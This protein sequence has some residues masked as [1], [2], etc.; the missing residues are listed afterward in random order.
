MK[1]S[2]STWLGPRARSYVVV[3]ATQGSDGLISFAFPPFLSSLEVPLD[4]IGLL[5]ACGG[6]AA[7]ASR[8]PAGVLY[9]GSRARGLLMVACT[10]AAATTFLLPHLEAPLAFAVL[11]LIGGFAYGVATTANLARFIDALPPGGDRARAMGFY[12]A[13]LALG[14]VFGN[15]IGGFAGQYLG[16][17]PAFQCAAAAY[18]LA[19]LTAATLPHPPPRATTATAKTV[20][21]GPRGWRRLTVLSDPGMLTV[22]LAAFLAAFMQQISGSFLPLYGLSVGLALSEVASVRMT[23]AL[24]NVF[25]RAG[26]GPLTE[27][28][29]RRRTQHVF[30]SLQA[31]GLFSLSFCTT[32]WTLLVAMLWVATCRAIVLVAN[33]ISLTEDVDEERVSR[34]VAS[35]LFNAATDLGNLASPALGGVVGAAFGLTN[36][37]RVLP[38]FVLAL[39]FVI[40]FGRAYVTGRRGV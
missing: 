5:V 13:A 31:I 30:I 7:L 27:R 35:G 4:L 29:G 3:A 9:R 12:S 14:L 33:T 39:Y 20:S 36:I 32:F 22:T 1:G 18:L 6:L 21:A 23:T 34:G 10:T 28:I 38:P 15:G 26:G 2:A 17:L 24:T 40:T 16:Y 11:R 25:A 37:F 19:A 8:L